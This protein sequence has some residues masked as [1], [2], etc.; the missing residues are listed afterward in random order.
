MADYSSNE[1]TVLD[2]QAKSLY[3]RPILDPQSHLTDSPAASIPPEILE[4]IL[5][6]LRDDAVSPDAYSEENLLIYSE[7]IRQTVL[8]WITVTRVCSS[9]RKMA[10]DYPALWTRIPLNMGPN[11]T[12]ALLSRPH[13]HPISI[14]AHSPLDLRAIQPV[15]GFLSR[16]QNIHVTAEPHTIKAL[17][18]SLTEPAPLLRSLTLYSNDSRV[19]LLDMPRIDETLFN[20]DAPLLQDV[21]I[22]NCTF[23][24]D[25]LV[26]QIFCDHLTPL[27]LTLTKE[28]TRIRPN[29][30]SEI[31]QWK[32]LDLSLQNLLLLLMQMPLLEVLQV[33]SVPRIHDGRFEQVSLP[34]LRSLMLT[35][36]FLR[37][38]TLSENIVGT[39]PDIFL[40]IQS[41]A[42]PP[43]PVEEDITFFSHALTQHISRRSPDILLSQ[44]DIEID[45]H[46]LKFSVENVCS[47]EGPVPDG[48]EGDRDRAIQL[49]IY[50]LPLAASTTLNMNI[51]TRVDADALINV[52]HRLDP[53][54]S[55][56]RRS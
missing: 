23:P 42:D 45:A 18:E 31:G 25:T 38:L 33:Q 3:S 15:T 17:L 44:V 16:F 49:S 28:D 51:C 13:S 56:T 46:H 1:L 47:L 22:A 30:N 27:H 4:Y 6:N 9:W 32:N 14:M 11:W 19:G 37:C 10:I 54:S 36:G 43:N 2:T 5:S 34:N 29:A 41:F 21:R 40:G 39:Q 50:A 8:T 52:W 55:T 12:K 48:W 26:L 53:L 35:G 24:K 7:Y 20:D